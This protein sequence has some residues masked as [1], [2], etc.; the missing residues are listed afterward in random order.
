MPPRR[1][2]RSAASSSSSAR[3]CAKPARRQHDEPSA[4]RVRASLLAWFDRHG[5][6]L[7][8]R[9]AKPSRRSARANGHA[10]ARRDPWLVWVSEIMLQQTRVE[11]VVEPYRRFVSAFPSLEALARADQADVLARWS[12]LGYY[13]RARLLHEGARY[14]LERCDGRIPR[15]RRELEDVPGIGSYTAG[16]ILSIAFGEREAALDANVTRVVARLCAVPD[17]RAGRAAL[18]R[19]AGALAD[20]DRPGDVN[21]ALMDLGSAVCTSREARCPACPLREQCRAASE[22]LASTIGAPQ[23]RKAPR[24]VELG[25]AVV[26]DG[27]RVLFLRRPADDALMADLWDLPTVD[28]SVAGAP[29]RALQTL[30]RKRSGF[31]ARLE[32]PLVKVRHD[33]VGRR[34]VASVYVA[35]VRANA[36]TLRVR[37]DARMMAETDLAGVGVPALPVK[38]L[39]ALLRQQAPSGSR[40]AARSS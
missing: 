10:A 33:I 5:R 14:V 34:I 8:W 35:S 6:A 24:L 21:E 30:V 17:P 11:A 36:R 23:P 9:T 13:R 31:D 2:A 1:A 28:A 38:I 27:D 37:D 15:K 3:S 16:A 32:G 29:Q 26:R 25:C 20:C 4:A 12:G 40:A 19:F 39:K 22:G 7:P 18:E